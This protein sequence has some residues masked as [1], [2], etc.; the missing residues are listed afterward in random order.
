MGAT[1]VEAWKQASLTDN[2][3]SVSVCTGQMLQ[4]FSAYTLAWN[5]P[6]LTIAILRT[7]CIVSSESMPPHWCRSNSAKL[8]LPGNYGAVYWDSEEVMIT[9]YLLRV[10]TVMGVYYTELMKK[11]LQLS[12][13]NAG[14]ICVMVC[15]IIATVQKHAHPQLPWLLFASTA[16]NCSITYHIL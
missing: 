3:M 1:N 7:S 2:F 12:R 10:N 15:C 5:T 4:I 16:S 8:P 13:K 14:E 6:W 11:V 9:D